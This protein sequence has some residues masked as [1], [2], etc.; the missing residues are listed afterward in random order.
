MNSMIRKGG[1]ETDAGSGKASQVDK[2]QDITIKLKVNK[3]CKNEHGGKSQG[4]V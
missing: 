4:W 2:W 3:K 1:G